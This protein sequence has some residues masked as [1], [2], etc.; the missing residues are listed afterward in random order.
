MRPAGKRRVQKLLL[1][2]ETGDGHPGKRTEL[3]QTRM[4]VLR[5]W[6]IKGRGERK[7]AESRGLASVRW[8]PS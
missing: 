6:T 1:A 2:V 3:C 5:K 8:Q 4:D 7:R